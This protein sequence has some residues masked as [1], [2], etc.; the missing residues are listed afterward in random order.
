MKCK[1][2]GVQGRRVRGATWSEGSWRPLSRG[3]K[4]R[5]EGVRT[6]SGKEGRWVCGRGDRMCQVLGRKDLEEWMV[7]VV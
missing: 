2:A 5:P 1:E 4:L 7:S 6:L 3:M